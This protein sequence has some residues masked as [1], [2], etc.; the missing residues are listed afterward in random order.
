[1]MLR[2]LSIIVCSTSL[3]LIGMAG[4]ALVDP[5]DVK[6]AMYDLVSSEEAASWGSSWVHAAVHMLIG[7]VLGLSAGIG[8]WL[9]RRWSMLLIFIACLW[10]L[11]FHWRSV[12]AGQG[13]WLQDSESLIEIGIL[14]V[15]ASLSIVFY[16]RWSH[17][18]PSPNNGF[19]SDAGKAGAE[20]KR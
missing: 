9:S 15:A 16:A 8:M 19:N 20:H 2:A 13:L 3:L 17:F 5:Y 10:L 18:A 1:M 4:Y 11:L 12:S 6:L 14:V 7:G